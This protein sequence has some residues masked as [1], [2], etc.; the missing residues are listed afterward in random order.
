MTDGRVPEFDLFPEEFLGAEVF[1]PYTLLEGD[2]LVAPP[3]LAAVVPGDV[4]LLAPTL[5]AAPGE[6]LLANPVALGGDGL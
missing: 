4:L 3:V 2:C 6:V 1:E 5:A